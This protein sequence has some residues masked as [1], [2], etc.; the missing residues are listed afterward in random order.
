MPFVS[1]QCLTVSSSH[2][3]VAS[4]HHAFPHCLITLSSRSLMVFRQASSPLTRSWLPSPFR[5]LQHCAKQMLWV[6]E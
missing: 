6:S 2:F 5:E 1:V 4:L 3:H